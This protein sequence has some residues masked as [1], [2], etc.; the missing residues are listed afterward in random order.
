VAKTLNA[1]WARAFAAGLLRGRGVTLDVRGRR[2]GQ[3]VSFPLVLT[4]Y[5]GERYLVS[6][7]GAHTQWVLNVRAAEGRAAMRSGTTESVRLVELDPA[8][9]DRGA[10]ILKRYLEV[11]PGAR[12]HVPVDRR[13]PL[14][15]FGQIVGD[16]PIF[17]ITRPEPTTTQS[18]D[19]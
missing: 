11:A 19:S 10:A 17:Q 12:P 2:T 4:T 1:L 13:A 15:A 8:E 7:L 16:F 14:A 5:Q 6:M 9:R 3:T 18:H